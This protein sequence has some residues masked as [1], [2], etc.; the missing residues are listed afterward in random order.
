MASMTIAS[1]C[2]TGPRTELRD[3]D[4]VVVVGAWRLSDGQP[5]R[6][7]AEEVRP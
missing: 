3:G 6:V 7:D 4:P 1:T 5:V 2:K